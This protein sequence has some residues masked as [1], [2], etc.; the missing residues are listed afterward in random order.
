[1]YNLPQGHIVKM[2]D[3]PGKLYGTDGLT[4]CNWRPT[5]LFIPVNDISAGDP[6]TPLHY[7]S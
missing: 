7:L 4:E 6:G 3:I 5:L 2:K 1:M